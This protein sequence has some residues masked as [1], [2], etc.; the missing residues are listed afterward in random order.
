MSNTCETCG[1]P[2]DYQGHA[3]YETWAARLW[4]DNEQ[5]SQEEAYGLAREAL[6][7]NDGDKELAHRD[8]REPLTEFV[9][10]LV[11]GEESS[12]QGLALDL[13]TSAFEEIDFWTWAEDLLDEVAEEVAV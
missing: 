12:V 6:A 10:E 3:N 9:R 1:K 7:D 11:Y 13:L 8:L 4:V 5:G 2:T